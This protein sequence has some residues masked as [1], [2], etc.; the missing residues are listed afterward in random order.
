MIITWHGDTCFTIKEKG[1]TLVIDPYKD[2][3][4]APQ[5]ADV[6]LLTNENRE[7]VKF[8]GEPKI[9]D[10]PGEY[11]TCDIPVKA[12]EAWDKSLS[13]EEKEG[14]GNPLN[15]FKFEIGGINLC[16]LGNIGHVLRSD[17]IEELGD[18]DVLFLSASE[19]SA[20]PAKKAHEIVEQTD[21]RVVVLMGTGSFGEF[22]KEV[23]ARNRVEEKLQITSKSEFEPDKT[24]FITLKKA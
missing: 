13:D 3:K 18:I 1:V 9:F 21:P 14:K 5:K 23:G 10:W 8:D 6:I 22:L 17:M 4:G 24:D 19:K 16:H 12:L 2:I 15:I 11:E 20:L 7:T